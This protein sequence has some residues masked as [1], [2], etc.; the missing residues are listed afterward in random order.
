MVVLRGSFVLLEFRTKSF[1][2]HCS[3]VKSFMYA[4]SFSYRMGTHTLQR[5]PAEVESEAF[6]FMR[7]MC[8]IVSGGDRCFIINI[9]QTPV[10][11]SMSST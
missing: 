7:F 9:Y 2:A 6:D 5:V 11:I 8:V 1:T 3:C 10:Y 4:H